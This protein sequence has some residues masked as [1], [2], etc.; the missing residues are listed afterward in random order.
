[1]LVTSFSNMADIE[2]GALLPHE[3]Y[4]GNWN[5][6]FSGYWIIGIKNSLLISA[7]CIVLTLVVSFPAAYVF[8]R[9]KFMADKHLFF[10]LLT[11]RMAPPIVFVL[12]FLVM[13]RA[14]GIWD[15]I[16]GVAL[17]YSLFN[18]PIAIWL[19]VS[20]MG[21]IPKEIDN[22]AFIDGY[23]LWGYFRR[24][25]IPL[26]APGIAVTCFFIWMFSWTEMLLASTLTSVAA[27]PLTVQ[28][29]IT[30]GRVGYGVQYGLAAAAGIITIIPGL[31]LLYW[32]RKYI[33]KGFTLGGV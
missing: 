19:L 21:G 14:F 28:L 6:V 23:S 26:N 18:V 17:A 30:M 33:A 10:W 4:L 16:P 24:I 27:K 1:M 29:L 7:L 31:A 15:T 22:A 13:F 32:A 8:S 9:Y 11:N 2:S 20:F 3:I 5:D 12:G 25:F